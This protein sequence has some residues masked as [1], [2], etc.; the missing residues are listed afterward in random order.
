MPWG[1]YGNIL[2]SGLLTV[3]DH[4][5]D[6]LEYP[7]IERVGPYFPDIYIV[8]SCNLI[9][10]DRVKTLLDSLPTRGIAGYRKAV[11]KKIVNIDWQS[12]D[13]DSK[14][15]LFYPKG[16]SPENYILKGENSLPLMKEKPEAWELLLSKECKMKQISSSQ[17]HIAY[18]NLAL[19]SYPELDIFQPENM[20]FVVV[21]ERFKEFIE[22]EGIFTLNF[23]ELLVDPKSE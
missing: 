6:D 7:E 1:D 20:L 21:S 3:L 8:N 13:F 22:Q 2:F 12:W 4:N 10:T 9:I 11:V 17:D 15:P 5:Y 18:T 19:S 14:D 16:N 23:I